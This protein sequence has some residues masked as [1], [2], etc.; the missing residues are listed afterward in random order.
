VERTTIFLV[1]AHLNL[2]DNYIVMSE[3][4]TQDLSDRSRSFEERVFA[5][6]DVIDSRLEKLEARAY[7][8]KPIWE[9]ALAQIMETGFEVGEIKTKVGV[10][11]GKVVALE[12]EVAEVKAKVTTMKTNLAG[13]KTEVGGMKTSYAGIRNELTDVR[14]E[15][16]HDIKQKLDLI[17]K[18]LLEDRE[19]IRDAEDRIRQLESK[20]A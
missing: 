3:E 15:L 20:L 7:D 17:L 1:D 19:D 2:A 5:R 11:E 10:I 4:P 18:F 6:F 8:T 13:V 14:R 9:R 12:T 16:R